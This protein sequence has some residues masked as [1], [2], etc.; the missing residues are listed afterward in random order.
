MINFGGIICFIMLVSCVNSQA[1][2]TLLS[3]GQWECN[4][5]TWKSLY[6][7]A[8]QFLR[9]GFEDI[10]FSSWMVDKKKY[11]SCFQKGLLKVPQGLDQN[12]Q[13]LDL[14]RNAIKSFR[15]SDFGRYKALI[16]VLIEENCF[17][18]SIIRT[19]IPPCPHHSF[20]IERNAFSS[21]QNLKYLDLS[22]NNIKSFPQ[23]L[24]KTIVVLN[25]AYTSMQ[26]IYTSDLQHLKSLEIALF[27]RNCFGK[28]M[29]DLCIGNFS[30][31]NFT[32]T[33]QNVS[34]LDLA[35]NNLREIPSWLFTSA[36]KV[37]DLGGNPI[38]LVRSSDFDKCI[39]L[40]RLILS[41][42]A[43]FELKQLR[44]MDG[45]FN[46]LL[47]LKYLDLAA[48]MLTT[49]PD[50]SHHRKLT[51]LKL[52][53]D[54]LEKWAQN[55]TNIS[56]SQVTFMALYGNTFCDNRVYPIK[57]TLPTLKLGKAY[58]NF[59][60]LSSLYIGVASNQ[61]TGPPSYRLFYDLAYG[62]KY[63]T[64]D[65][66]SLQFLKH[67]PKLRVLSLAFNGI[68][69]VDMSAFCGFKLAFLDLGVNNIEELR[70]TSLHLNQPDLSYATPL[71][72][73]LHN[74]NIKNRE[75]LSLILARNAIS[76][77]KMKAFKCFSSTTNL[78]L[79]RN[80]ITYIQ[81]DTFRYMDRL[82]TLNLEFNPLRHIEF[83][84]VL[85]IN[86]LSLNYTTYQGEF[87]LKFLLSFTN[88]LALRYGDV[89]DNIYELLRAYRKN[90][91]QFKSVRSID[92]SYITVSLYDVLSNEPIFSPFPNLEKLKLKA[93]SITVPLGSNLFGEVPYITDLTLSYC[94]I[95]LFPVEALKKLQ[96]LKHLDLSHNEIESL[97]KSWF[98]GIHSL[99]KL[100]I[101]HNFIQYIEP[102]TLQYLVQ[103]GLKELELNNNRITDVR[104]H[105]IDQNTLSNLTYLDIRKNPM[106]CDCSLTENFGWLVYSSYS[107]LNIPGFFPVCS[108]VLENYFG[109]CLT[110]FGS[111]QS[112]PH[113]LF[114]YSLSSICQKQFLILLTILYVSI[115][116]FFTTISL[117]CHSKWIQQ[118]IFKFWMRRS[119][120]QMIQEKE[121]LL[122]RSNPTKIFA[123]D[124]FVYYDKDDRLLADWV[125]DIMVPKLE[126]GSPSLR[127]A[128]A[129]KEEWCGATWVK[130]DLLKI[131]ASRKTVVLL[132]KNFS[133]TPQCRYVLSVLESL[134]HTTGVD[135]T[136]IVTFSQQPPT[137][138]GFQ[139]RCYRNSS[140]VLNYCDTLIENSDNEIFWDMLRN[141]IAISSHC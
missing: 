18:N 15:K 65:A 1:V 7:A 101:S 139:M 128:V 137:Q 129:G 98:V 112:E 88:H 77:L 58:Q 16:A 19:K 123:F 125:D 48:N 53:Y 115:L 32:F 10:G 80:S 99:E 106:Y 13:I 141:A 35:F 124:G 57:S 85:N 26:P 55:P 100:D 69:T 42:T 118:K 66:E 28:S 75:K 89:T 107:K 103:G 4:Q 40:E 140:S 62:S 2:P 92:F 5:P 127:V 96:R 94:L 6:D 82:N 29:S 64:V 134:L 95:R 87:T 67:L 24:P 25:I 36:L 84:L 79:S 47:N 46:N 120:L 45:A 102:G 54:C 111:H 131:E 117:V 74:P 59:T 76:S 30:V 70:S 38:H 37:L 44:I 83:P 86:Q 20:T 133:Q 78:D 61:P 105:I 49:L 113:S 39:Q 50:F 41:W 52:G 130:Q 23:G 60:Q 11:V 138:I 3:Y 21:M 63:N 71:A 119:R 104:P 34:Y 126:N 8:P 22:K 68:K 43:E 51:T 122:E 121:N 93:A 114:L 73:R 108:D 90:S 135:K 12:I 81:G 116:L 97:N 91:T 17:S 56:S 109:G 31:K 136:V 27:G 110:C 9:D 72:D 14:R 33:S 132:T